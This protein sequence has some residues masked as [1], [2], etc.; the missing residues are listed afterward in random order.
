MT[1][2]KRI[3]Q[4]HLSVQRLAELKHGRFSNLSLPD[5]QFHF[6]VCVAVRCHFED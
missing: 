3:L 1:K 2:Q 4:P 6:G 5:V